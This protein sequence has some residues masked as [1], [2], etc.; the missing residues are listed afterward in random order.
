ML[1][2]CVVSSQFSLP[3]LYNHNT[4]YFFQPS[5]FITVVVRLIS[6]CRP[7]CCWTAWSSWSTQRVPNPCYMLQRLWPNRTSWSTYFR[8][9]FMVWITIIRMWYIRTRRHGTKARRKII[10]PRYFNEE[11]TQQKILLWISLKNTSFM[12]TTIK[13]FNLLWTL[14][15]TFISMKSN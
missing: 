2:F 1:I 5:V 13:F 15:I 9:I 4:I 10:V 7:S 11:G 12:C 3:R 6:P 8:L 14:Y